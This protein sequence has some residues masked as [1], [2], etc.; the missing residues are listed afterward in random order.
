MKFK[1]L[2]FVDNS[3]INKPVAASGDFAIFFDNTPK[4]TASPVVK[5]KS[6]GGDFGGVSPWCVR[7]I[8]N[9]IY[10]FSKRKKTPC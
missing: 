6:I 9:S 10:C 8:K 2:H 1:K 7:F 4:S 3:V 5:P